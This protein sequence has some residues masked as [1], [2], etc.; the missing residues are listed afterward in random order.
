MLFLVP[1]RTKINPR[2]PKESFDTKMYLNIFV[3][4]ALGKTINEKSK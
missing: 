4:E 1:K 3:G 2:E